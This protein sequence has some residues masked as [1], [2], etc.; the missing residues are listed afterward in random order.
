[1][2]LTRPVPPAPYSF[3]PPVPS[4]TLTS[5]DMTEGAA[6]DPAFT[7][8]GDNASPHLSW[9]GFPKETQSFLVNMFDPDAPTPAGWWHW[10]IV[11]LPLEVTELNRGDGASDLMLP[12]AAFH[13][14]NDG[15]EYDYSGSAPPRGDR[16]HRYVFAVHA[17]DVDTFDADPDDG[18]TL[19]AFKAV[20]HTIARATLTATFQLG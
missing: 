9:S 1:M 14:R 20:F 2:D 18:A 3:L 16:A 19:V 13:V 12:G 15:G 4:F 6:L 11:D 10:T 8:G 17:L 7:A 5:D